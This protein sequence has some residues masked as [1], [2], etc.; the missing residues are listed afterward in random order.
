MISSNCV[1]ITKEQAKKYFAKGKII[2]LSQE[3]NWVS[4][5]VIYDDEE[6]C[7]ECQFRFEIDSFL[8]WHNVSTMEFEYFV[9]FAIDRSDL[10]E[11]ESN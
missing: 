11:N 5:P 8:D 1:E 3:S 7:M 4:K 9:T 6:D 2:Y 10:D